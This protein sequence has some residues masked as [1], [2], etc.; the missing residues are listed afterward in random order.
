[1]TP[2]LADLRQRSALVTGAAAGLGH[3][4][5][6][7]LAQAGATVVMHCMRADDAARA[8][9]QAM[10]ARHGGRVLLLEADLR[11]AEQVE[12]MAGRA[13]GELARLDIVVNNAVMRHFSPAHELPR[14][15]WD[16]AL[17][18]NLSAAFHLARLALPGMLAQRW[19]RIINIASV[20][21]SEATA[22]R[23]GYITTKTALLGLTR[24]LAVETAATGVTCNAVSPGT[25]P[26]PA[27]VERIADIARRDGVSVEQAERAYLAERQPTG[28]FVAMENVAA[29]AAFLCSEA[30]RDITGANLPI[31]G[32]WTAA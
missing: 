21:A 7:T 11:D 20:Y 8:A 16:E 32:G 13:L 5:A 25:A 19:G 10:A 30:G 17:A 29:L 3:A 27:I 26:T 9:Q 4:I 12:A 14:A 2:P 24:A 1:M 23:V 6:D 31:D 18:V 15:H 22:N 28:R